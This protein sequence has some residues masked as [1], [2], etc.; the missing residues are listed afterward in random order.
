VELLFLPQ[1]VTGRWPVTVAWAIKSLLA[2]LLLPP[3][4][5]LALLGLAG[6]TVG[7]AGLWP[8][9]GRRSAAPVAIA[10]AGRFGADGHAG[11]PGRRL[12]AGYGG[13]QAIVILGSGLIRP[14]AEFGGETATDRS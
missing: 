8:G 6:F 1:P 9:L 10:A 12:A 11:R 3:G 5:G 2:A 13:A 4:N 7:G 14:V